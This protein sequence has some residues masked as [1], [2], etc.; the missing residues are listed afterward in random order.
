MR[1]GKVCDPGRSAWETTA[2]K[3]QQSR[4]TRGIVFDGENWCEPTERA[5]DSHSCTMRLRKKK[6]ELMNKQHVYKVT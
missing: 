3:T 2:W 4:P 5:T 1:A 6:I